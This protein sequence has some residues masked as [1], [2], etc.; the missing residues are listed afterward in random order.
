MP[1]T[2][3]TQKTETP[4]V[5]PISFS[6]EKIYGLDP[7]VHWVRF[8]NQR[9]QFPEI[10][11]EIVKHWDNEEWLKKLVSRLG[12][13]LAVYNAET[14]PTGIL[15]REAKLH[16]RYLPALRYF[17]LRA[18]GVKMELIRGM[19]GMTRQPR[20]SIALL[21]KGILTRLVETRKT[22]SKRTGR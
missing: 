21:E 6:D 9:E 7:A 1:D 13:E 17:V 5:D 15:T 18:A 8:N 22:A 4:D 19:F 20:S 11:D 2:I 12:Y 16:I 14:K 10:V 3:P